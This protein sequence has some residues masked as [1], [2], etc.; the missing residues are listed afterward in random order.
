MTSGFSVDIHRVAR[1]RGAACAR[2]IGISSIGGKHHRPI[3]IHRITLGQDSLCTT[4]YI[5]GA[6]VHTFFCASAGD[7]NGLIRYL[8]G[9]G[10]RQRQGRQSVHPA[11]QNQGSGNQRRELFLIFLHDPFHRPFYLLC[12]PYKSFLF[13]SADRLIRPFLAPAAFYFFSC[14]V[15]SR[16]YCVFLLPIY[17]IYFILKNNPFCRSG[18]FFAK[19][20]VLACFYL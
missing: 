6:A 1:G 9:L 2:S 4:L 14:P 17:F 8:R 16:K 18:R 10:Q 5:C 20:V 19:V 12:I 7:G 15:C 13:S 3:D 11:V